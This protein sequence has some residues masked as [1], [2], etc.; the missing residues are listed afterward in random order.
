MRKGWAQKPALKDIQFLP[1]A[2]PTN[3]TLQQD[4]ILKLIH[5]S[6]IDPTK[7]S[8]QQKDKKV[9]ILSLEV[10]SENELF[11]KMFCE[12]LSKATSNFYIETKTKKSRNNVNILQYQVDS[13]KNA[14]NGA[15]TGV[16]NEADNV[17]NLN[18]AFNVKGAASK[19]R[20]VDVQSNTTI[21]TNLVVQLEL[22]KMALRKETPLIQIIDPPILPLEKTKTSKLKSLV[23]GGFLAGFLTILYLI[24]SKLFKKMLS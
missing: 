3:F 18:P 24:F 2:N 5:K 22:S 21:L 23:L 8:I 13:V 16:A 6:L 14:L 20:Q 11:S 15:I 4:S 7:L 10:T 19:K 9:T 17:Y 12:N 1:N